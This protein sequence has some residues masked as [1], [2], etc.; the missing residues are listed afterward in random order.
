[1]LKIT[2]ERKRVI[3]KSDLLSPKY[4]RFSDESGWMLDDGLKFIPSLTC[5]QSRALTF[6]RDRVTVITVMPGIS[7][8]R[9]VNNQQDS[10]LV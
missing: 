4:S 6:P 2:Y 7:L 10:L 9:S 5:L 1:M 3:L 8:S